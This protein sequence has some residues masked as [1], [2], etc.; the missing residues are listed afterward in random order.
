MRRFLLAS[1]LAPSLLLLSSLGCSSSDEAAPPATDA[2]ADGELPPVEFTPSPLPKDLADS[3]ALPDKRDAKVTWKTDTVVLDEKI[4]RDALTTP[5][6]PDGWYHFKKGTVPLAGLD[7]G[8]V[9]V[10]PFVGVFKITDANEDDTGVHV[11]TETA[12][13]DDAIQDGTL[14]WDVALPKT[15][16]DLDGEAPPAPTGK[17][18]RGKIDGWDIVYTGRPIPTG[19]TYRFELSGGEKTGESTVAFSK[20]AYVARFRAFG[21]ARVEGGRLV[22]ATFGVRD[23][24]VELTAKHGVVSKSFKK[25]FDMPPFLVMPFLVGTIPLFVTVGTNVEMESTAAV[26]TSVIGQTKLTLRGNGRYELRTDG[27]SKVIGD[28]TQL[29]VQFQGGSYVTTLEV[30]AGLFVDV[31]KI[32]FGVGLPQLQDAA[33]SWLRPYLDGL[34]RGAGLPPAALLRQATVAGIHV[35]L[36]GEIVQNVKVKLDSAGGTPVVK[37]T[38]ATVTFG[39]AAFYGGE[40]SFF[41]SRLS[42]LL[43]LDSF[44]EDKQLG[45][46]VKAPVRFGPGCAEFPAT[47]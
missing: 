27:T 26:D 28:L 20:V 13:L 46:K 37:A 36:V 2:G 3:L 32:V 41:A 47:P 11:G 31:P 38:C 6:S 15:A 21:N 22:S 12:A 19:D 16:L 45:G 43:M 10:I 8:K 30:G 1:V 39:A 17:D 5:F 35:K 42:S 18:Y 25:K 4:I 40:G 14:D 9:L 7:A 23:V 33:P 29:D 24:F 44:I 34:W